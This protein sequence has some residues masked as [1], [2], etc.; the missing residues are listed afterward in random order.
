MIDF[1]L[2]LDD[3]FIEEALGSAVQQ[4]PAH[5]QENSD[6]DNTTAHNGEVTGNTTSPKTGLPMKHH[7]STHAYTE[8]CQGPLPRHLAER[9]PG[10]I[11]SRICIN[12]S[13]IL[14]LEFLTRHEDKLP[15]R[16]DSGEFY[17]DDLL[18]FRFNL[19]QTLVHEIGHALQFALFGHRK[20]LKET[21][22]KDSKITEAGF[23]VEKL[24]FGGVIDYDK[25]EQPQKK[26]RGA[27]DPIDPNAANPLRPRFSYQELPS[28]RI[29]RTYREEFGLEI[30]REDRHERHDVFWDIPTSW[31]ASLFTNGF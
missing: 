20:G 27:R 16:L 29:A 4:G 11:R 18:W 2:F 8:P 19:A 3:R 1:D 28:L 6:I 10:G 15:F 24:L 13:R 7:T 26:E 21:K 22:Y 25:H 30:W 14:I 9:F 31:V 17:E 5:A 23:E 12:F